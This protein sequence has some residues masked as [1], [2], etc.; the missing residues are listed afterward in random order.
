MLIHIYLLAKISEAHF[1]LVFDLQIELFLELSFVT[2]VHYC[3]LCELV[4]CDLFFTFLHWVLVFENCQVFF[5]KTFTEL[6]DIPVSEVL[7]LWHSIRFVDS[8][9]ELSFFECKYL[10]VWTLLSMF[11]TCMLVVCSSAT[12]KDSN[13]FVTGIQKSE[14]LW[15][16]LPA[17]CILEWY[18]LWVWYLPVTGRSLNKKVG[19]LIHLLL[20][21]CTLPTGFA[22]YLEFFSDLYVRMVIGLTSPPLHKSYLTI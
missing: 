7:K 20:I 13:L 9:S 10:G 17:G 15:L 14:L 22:T 8:N 2:I 1:H 4:A 6:F 16:D 3:S 5:L 11:S 21:L 19:L 12:L 18:D